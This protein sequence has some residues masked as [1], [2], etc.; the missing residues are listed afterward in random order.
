MATMTVANIRTAADFKADMTNSNFVSSAEQLTYINAAYRSF[1]DIITSRFEDYNLGTPTSFTIA[2]GASTY[3]LAS[4]FYKLAGIDRS[5]GNGEFYPLRNYPWRSRN[6]YQ[7]SFSRYGLHPRIGYRVMGQRIQFLPED[8]AP[9]DY[10]IWY[11]PL[12]T[13]LALETDTVEGYNGF[14]ELVI[15]NTAIRQLMKEESDVSLLMAERQMEMERMKEMLID[16]DIN[17]GN[18]I[19]EVDRGLQYSDDYLGYE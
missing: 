8:Q 1:Y 18:R 17:D 2:S 6:R 9:G 7:A 3:T 15:I 16:R 19:E 12:P 14:E 13:A 11:I 5:T 4:D 10:Q